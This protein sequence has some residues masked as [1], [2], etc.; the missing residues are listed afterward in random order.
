VPLLQYDAVFSHP[1]ALVFGKASPQHIVI[2]FFPRNVPFFL[3]LVHDTWHPVKDGRDE[4][5][6]RDTFALK[7]V[8]F[9]NEQRIIGKL[10]KDGQSD[11][12]GIAA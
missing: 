9:Q 3:S 5:P 2:H 1:K 8:W 4:F 11:L 10:I 7:L 12:S 6:R